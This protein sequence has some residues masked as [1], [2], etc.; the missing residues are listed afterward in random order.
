[1]NFDNGDFPRA[2]LGNLD[3]L[4]V[5][6]VE[7]EFTLTALCPVA[8]CPAG[9]FRLEVFTGNGEVNRDVYDLTIGGGGGTAGPEGPRGPEGVAGPEGPEGPIGPIGPKGDQGEQ[10]FLRAYTEINRV[11][12]FGE[13]EITATCA[14]DDVAVGGG[15]QCDA[16]SSNSCAVTEFHSS[17]KSSTIGWTVTGV[18]PAPEDLEET[19]VT[20]QVVCL[21]LPDSGGGAPSA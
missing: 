18:V 15:F 14:S 6:D 8:G 5:C 21:D 11:L 10:G 19:A 12:S 17:F 16:E 7:S 1:M 20:V 4:E 3:E 9:D 13:Y 2:I